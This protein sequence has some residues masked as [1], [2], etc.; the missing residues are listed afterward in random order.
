MRHTLVALVALMASIVSAQTVTKKPPARPAPPPAAVAPAPTAA[1][2]PAPVG[3]EK[4]PDGFLGIKIGEAFAVQACPTRPFGQYL[5]DPTLDYD[6]MKSLEGVCFDPTDS[7]IK[8]ARASGPVTYKIKNLPA[9]G[10]GYDVSAWMKEGVV[11]RI[12]VSLKQSS[13]D[14]LYTAFRERYGKPTSIETKTVK[15]QAGAEFNATDV[16]WK[17]RKL[18]IRMYERMTRV[19]ESYVSISDNAIMEKEMEAEKQKRSSEAQKF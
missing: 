19:D 4:E 1:P 5:R 15:T 12:T 17:G 6:S 11:S 2:E 8:Y 10:I 16:F 7:S 13:F 9:L 14:V 3:W 18:S